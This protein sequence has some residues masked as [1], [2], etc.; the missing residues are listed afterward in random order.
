MAATD[1]P[2]GGSA[3]L[4]LMSAALALPILAVPARASAAEVSEAGFTLLGYRERG[5][6]RVTEPIAWIKGRFGDGWEVQASALVDVVSGASPEGTSNV[7]GRPVQTIS[8]ASVDDRRRQGDVKLSRRIGELTLAASGAWSTEEDYYSRAFGLEAK[9]DLDQRNTTLAAGFGHSSD[10]IGSS[11]DPSLDEPRTT[12]E[13]LLGVTQVLSRVAAVQ[14]TLTHARGSGWYSDPY[15]YTLTVFPGAGLDP[16]FMRDARPS[17]RESWAWLTRYRH[18][19]VDAEG[20]LQA[21]YR[22]FAD[23]WAVRA[24]TLDVAWQQDLGERWALRPALRYYTQ[25]AARFYS[26]VVT[27]PQPEVLSSDQRLAS[28]GGLSPSLR[29][30][31]RLDGGLA[32]E[33]TAGY[34]H[35][36][37]RLRLGGSGTA[38]FET[39]RAYYGIVTISR[40]F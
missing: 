3:L 33:A 25:R 23:D 28:F 13:Y 35:N 29:A 10:R 36:A 22:Y 6:M 16:V 30:I 38:A 27:L 24:H 32:I 14:S 7:S 5:L 31:L 12:R 26:P 17:R 40:V 20:T 15:R 37:A 34:V 19:F 8:G 39:L 2:A 1:P 4:A 21:D 9:L 18:R 11:D